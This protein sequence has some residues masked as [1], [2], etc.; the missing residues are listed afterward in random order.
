MSDKTHSFFKKAGLWLLS[1]LVIMLTAKLIIPLF[2]PFISAFLLALM[3][4]RP[5][6]WLRKKFHMKRG[7]ASALTVT[8][9]LSVLLGAAVLVL[10]GLVS[11]AGEYLSRMPEHIGR[12]TL[13][14]PDIS[15][16]IDRIAAALP[17]ELADIFR[18][19][20][21]NIGQQAASL[22]SRLYSKVFSLMSAAAAK[23]P[24][25]LLSLAMLALGLYFI[26]AGL[27]GIKTFLLRQLPQKL[28]NKMGTLKAD[29]LATFSGWFKAQLMLMSVCFAE[30]CA[31]F[32]LMRLN[33]AI[34]IAAMTALIDA[35]PVFGIGIV[36]IPWAGLCLLSGNYH[37]ALLIGLTYA[38][39]SLVRSFLE[40]RLLGK[41]MGLH[42]AAALM[43]VYGGFRISGVSG[44]ILFPVALMLL[45][46]FN[47]RGWLKLWH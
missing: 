2:W 15:G 4:D 17:R 29:V 31:A 7:F 22:P 42:P 39:V 20:A 6:E 23:A 10:S 25:I 32:L 46:Q 21:E 34:L 41:Q 19:M 18:S 37:R 11:A 33:N 45:K 36:L 38:A 35:L 16:S 47:D 12:I 44:M 24:S 26:S 14:S 9:F 8:L 13:P 27:P 3:L 5:I 28:S 1:A 43:A 40:P 30:L